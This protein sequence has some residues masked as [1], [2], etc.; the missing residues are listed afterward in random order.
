MHNTDIRAE[1]KKN[2]DFETADLIREELGKEGIIL[3]DTKEGT[4][5]DLKA[6]YNFN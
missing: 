4:N 6:L 2:K 1:A 3:N 5:W